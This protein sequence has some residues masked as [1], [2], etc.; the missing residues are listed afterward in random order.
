MQFFVCKK[1][2]RRKYDQSLNFYTL[3]FKN[4]AQILKQICV[5]NV[6]IPMKYAECTVEKK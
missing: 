3:C 1:T 2:A 6:E 4:V 5:C